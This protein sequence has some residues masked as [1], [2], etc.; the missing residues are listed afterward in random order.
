MRSRPV[1]CFAVWTLGVPSLLM[2]QW[3]DPGAPIA[4]STDVQWLEKIA[5]S[6]AGA[7]QLNPRGGLAGHVKDVRTA[8]YARLGAI[9]TEESLQAIERIE[10]AARKVSITPAT[11]PL[12]TWVHPCWHF[13][14]SQP[15][16]LV[17]V[18]VEDG[19]TYALLLG[20]LLGRLDFFLISSKTPESKDSWT[21]PLLVDMPVFR[22]I[23][24]PALKEKVPGTLILTYTQEAPEPRSLMEGELGPPASAPQLG[25]QTRELD[26]AGLRRDADSDGWTDIEERRLGLD[27]N[28]PDTDGDGLHD[29]EDPCPDMAPGTGAAADEKTEIV[30]RAIFATFGIS[31]SHYLILVEHQSE[32]VQLWGYSGP[33]LY[34]SDSDQWRKEYG[35]GA[36]FVRWNVQV[37]GSRASVRI[38]D[39]EG[40]LAGSSQD[41]LLRKI[42]TKWYVVERRLGPVS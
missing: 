1:W 2:G 41:V 12:D 42:G 38:F 11:L 20:Y 19:T 28:N 36:I 17:Q 5:G 35:E 37:D 10:Q 8:A 9:G 18:K 29:G 39:W 3:Y 22:G 25:P 21:R 15:R 7:L 13:A 16:P 24:D 27:P 33:V 4:R 23:K 30:Q 26:L 14:D 40:P 31:G 32:R 6:D 34:K